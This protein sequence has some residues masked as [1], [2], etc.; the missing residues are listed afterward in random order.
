[1][2]IVLS[3]ALLRGE[4]RAIPSK[5]DAHRLL[6]CAALSDAPTF[7]G[8]PETS[9]DIDATVRCLTALGAGIERVAEGFRVTPGAPPVSCEMDCGESGSTLRFLLPVVCALGVQAVIRMHGRLPERPLEPLWSELIRGGADLE[10]TGNTILVR[11]KLTE[12]NYTLAADVSSQFLSGILFALP[13]LGGGTL[14]LQGR[15]QSAGYLDMTIRTLSRFG[16]DVEDYV[17]ILNVPPYGYESPGQ[18]TAEGDWSNAAFWLAAGALC[19]DSVLCTG[20]DTTSAQGDRAVV[21]ALKAIRKGNA[22]LHAEQ[23]PDLVPVLSVVAALTPGKT[24]ITGAER[25][26][27]KESDRL[28]AT[29]EL[30]RGLGGRAEAT[31]DGLIIE[32]K[33]KLDGGTA[34]SRGDH[35]IAMSAAVASVGCKKAVTIIGAEAV[36]KSYPGF[37]RDF[38]ALGGRCKEVL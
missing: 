1:M 17:G 24:V 5:S 31:D 3:P 2:K 13:L 4:I 7:V 30:I 38:A 14:R 21:D 25:L 20:L 34:D 29:A 9:E 23:I 16:V 11:G 37:F 33:K 36:R 35:R 19:G 6:I 26:K 15:L 27:L 10:K 28:A 12:K 8:C 22:V 18:V 32:G